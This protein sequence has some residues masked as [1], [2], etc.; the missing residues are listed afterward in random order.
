M[1]G[2]TFGY[3]VKAQQELLKRQRQRLAEFQGGG[4]F[5]RTTG[6]TSGTTETGVGMAQ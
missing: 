1:L 6:A 4:Q 5:A 2:A 3:D